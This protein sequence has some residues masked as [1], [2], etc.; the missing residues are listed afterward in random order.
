MTVVLPNDQTEY[1]Y[2]VR[3]HTVKVMG[4]LRS[5]HAQRQLP[6]FK[7]VELNGMR[8]VDPHQVSV[9]TV[10]CFRRHHIQGEPSR[11]AEYRIEKNR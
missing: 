4:I 3:I 7:V 10:W 11:S 5:Q 2:L 6:N 1:T 8:L 9:S